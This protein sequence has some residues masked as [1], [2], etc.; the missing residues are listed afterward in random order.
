[1]ET[2]TNTT[3]TYLIVTT[4]TSSTLYA[5]ASDGTITGGPYTMRGERR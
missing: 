1:M 3:T 4:S 2:T 5:V